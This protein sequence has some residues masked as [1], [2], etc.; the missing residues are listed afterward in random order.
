MVCCYHSYSGVVDISLAYMDELSLHIKGV[1]SGQLTSLP[2]QLPRV[3]QS[4]CRAGN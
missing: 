1:K 3:S 4:P 2:A